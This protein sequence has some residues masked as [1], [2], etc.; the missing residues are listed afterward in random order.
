MWNRHP[1]V[2]QEKLHKE[3]KD[4]LLGA[5]IRRDILDEAGLYMGTTRDVKR[6][7]GEDRIPRE[8]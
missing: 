6:V 8:K 1:E 3:E 7:T 2:R 4:I 5:R